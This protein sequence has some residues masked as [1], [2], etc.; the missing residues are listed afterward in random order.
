MEARVER[1]RS[2]RWGVPFVVG[3][4]LVVA[5]WILF[6]AAGAT[7]VATILML[8]I[9]LIG[10]GLVGLVDAFRRKEQEGRL[11]HVLTGVL[12]MAVGVLVLLRPL[13]SLFAVTILLG[14]YFFVSGLFRGITA[15]AD[16][17][18]GWGWDLFYG[19]VSVLLAVIVVRSLPESSIWLVGA[20]VGAEIVVRGVVVMAGALTLRRLLRHGTIARRVDQPV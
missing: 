13:A 1:A 5:G 10:A 6:T 11:A 8:G 4:L 19:V 3:L 7:S 20:L 15:V 2:A 14:A 9:F 12:S 17:Y 18:R 16:R